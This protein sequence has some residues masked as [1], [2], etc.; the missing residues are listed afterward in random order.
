MTVKNDRFDAI[1][2]GSGIGGLTAASLLAQLQG[3]RVLVLEQH[4]RAGGFT[5]SFRRQGYEWDVGLHYLGGLAPGSDNRQLFELVTGGQ[6][7]LTPLPDRY[8]VVHLDGER[9]AIP[10]DPRQWQEELTARFLQEAAGIRGWFADVARMNRWL[11]IR[12][13]ANSAPPLLAAL[14][15]A[16]TGSIGHLARRT[17]ADIIAGHVRDPRLRTL[18]GARWGDYGVPPERGAFGYHALILG[19]YHG[20]AFFPVG[21]GSS[22]AAA[23]TRIVQGAGG[24]VR[25]NARVETVLVERDRAVGVRVVDAHGVVSEVRAP[26]VISDAGAARTLRDLVPASSAAS[27]M[28]TRVDRLPRSPS[29]VT[30]YMGLSGDPRTVGVDGANHWVGRGASGPDGDGCATLDELRAA[31]GPMAFL[32]FG[33]VN[34][35]NARRHTAQ[36]LM[37]TCGD[38]FATWSGTAWRE[39]G[40]DYARV[41][42]DI[43][44][45]AMALADR[46]MPGLAGLVDYTEVSTPLTV[47]RFTGHAGGAIYGLAVTPERLAAGIGARTPVRGLLLAGADICTPGIQGA[48]MGGVFAAS[49]ALG[50]AGLPR[51]M[52]TAKRGPAQ[53]GVRRANHASRSYLTPVV[54]SQQTPV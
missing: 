32:S 43:A 49:A 46:L 34:D 13:Y 30:V 29:A 40:D 27:V 24:E 37:L 5:H 7:E 45:A 1:V 52:A 51:I 23:V 25:V 11:G 33:S 20:G 3:K 44:T 6:I 36:L 16:A 21:G 15:R 50:I 47:E 2:I 42:A 41:K 17:T 18:L 8:D 54:T 12:L 53:S 31:S 9:F 26:L 38:A 22:I 4:W 14:I 10:A 48:M 28:A 35:P 19:S 39:R